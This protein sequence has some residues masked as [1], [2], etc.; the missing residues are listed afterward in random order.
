M[1]VLKEG[2]KIK[3]LIQVCYDLSRPD[4]KKREVRALI[5]ASKE[6][7]CRNLLVITENKE[8]S[9][10]II[11]F[12]TKRKINYIPLWKWLLD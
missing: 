6:L 10:E 4:T 12:G 5:N 2:P 11:W 7:G 3:Q 1:I 8:G 9:E